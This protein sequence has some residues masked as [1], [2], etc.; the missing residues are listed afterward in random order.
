MATDDKALQL[1]M[2]LTDDAL[3]CLLLL[4]PE[5]RNR[6]ETLVGALQRRF[7]QCLESGVLRNELGNRSRMPGESLRLLAN[8]IESLTRRAYGHMPSEV[9]SE[10]ARDQFIRALTPLTSG[11]RPHA[12]HARDPGCAGGVVR[13]ATC[14]ED[15]PKWLRETDRARLGGLSKPKAITPTTLSPSQFPPPSLAFPSQ[16]LRPT[17]GAQQR[18]RGPG[19]TS[20]EV[21]DI[22]V[23]EPTVVVG[24]AGDG[25]SCYEEL[26]G[27]R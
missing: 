8:D 12:S 10:L 4:S 23:S 25:D 1:A 2:C 5:D 14:S 18:S 16:P 6:Y 3:P 19:S 7:G 11:L 27:F 20:P 21:D 15:A 22:T 26:Y 17:G 13:R 24:R 9:Q